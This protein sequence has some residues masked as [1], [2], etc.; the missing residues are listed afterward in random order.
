MT[1]AIVINAYNRPYALARLLTSLGRAHYPAGSKIPLVISL[2]PS[3]KT[4]E[5]RAVAE[6][7][8]WPHG[9]KNIIVHEQHLGLVRHFFACG[10]LSQTLGSIILLE[11]DEVVSP[12]FYLFAQQAMTFYAHDEAIGG[13]SLYALW[14][15]GYTRQPFTPLPDEA[16]VYFLQV[17]FTQ[18]PAFTPSQWSGFRDWCAAQHADAGLADRM[19]P[20]WFRFP[21]NDWFPLLAKY[22]VATRRYFVC[23]RVS[24][25]TNFGDTGTHFAQS[26]LFFQA[27]LQRG[28][29][30]YCLKPLAESAIVYDSFFEL[31]PERLNRMTDCLHSYV[32]DVDLNA[33][34]SRRNLPSEYVLTS[35]LCRKALYSF[36]KLM[37]PMEANV[38]DQVP[39]RGI[40]FCRSDDVRWDRLAEWSTLKSNY[41]FSSR[42]QRPGKR[43][44]LQFALAG[45][46]GNVHVQR[47]IYGVGR[48]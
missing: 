15:N 30:V 16:D 31:L 14:F 36:G 41:E 17:P 32:Y 44:Y 48:D 23:P 25:V 21:P 13:V 39:G 2:D 46:L 27:P 28:K 19:H 37:Q 24:L 6:Q 40:Y 26:T 42:G 9:P 11:D 38:I 45:L 10:D 43:R 35:R 1:P 34:K 33:I 12:V 29:A 4:P 5:V 7:F 3:E 18:G 20:A 22:L 8:D 47:L